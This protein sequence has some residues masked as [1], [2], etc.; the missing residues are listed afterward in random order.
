MMDNINASGSEKIIVGIYEELVNKDI[1][2]G[3]FEGQEGN[4][5]FD[6]INEVI[7]TYGEELA[8]EIKI[9]VTCNG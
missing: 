1:I 8:S 2:N 5:L 9:N 7:D 4:K 6:S 3:L